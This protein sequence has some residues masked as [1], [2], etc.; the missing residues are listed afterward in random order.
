MNMKISNLAIPKESLTASVPAATAAAVAA[1]DSRIGKQF[2]ASLSI[3]LA[4]K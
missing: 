2:T 3:K 4:S 1:T